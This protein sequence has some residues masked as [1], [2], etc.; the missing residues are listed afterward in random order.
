MWSGCFPIRFYM[1]RMLFAAFG[2]H[3]TE[4]AKLTHFY[5]WWVGRFV[6]LQLWTKK[7]LFNA[8]PLATWKPIKNLGSPCRY[9]DMVTFS[10]KR[11]FCNAQAWR[12]TIYSFMENN[13]FILQFHVCGAH[14]IFV[15]EKRFVYFWG[16]V[17]FLN[18][19][20][21]APVPDYSEWSWIYSETSSV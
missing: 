6:L 2:E 4:R 12:A 10:R 9:H 11:S 14:L 21:G 15:T 8:F 5:F 1:Y 20:A 16:Q 18:Y 3:L 19:Y 7:Y 17:P 13:A